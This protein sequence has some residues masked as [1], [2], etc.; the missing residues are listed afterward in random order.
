MHSLLPPEDFEVI[1]EQ[2]PGLCLIFD[3]SFRILAQN[4][5]HALATMTKRE[6]AIGRLLYEVF[7]DNPNDANAEGLAILRQS[8]VTV[9]KTCKPDIVPNLK[10]AIERQDG[11][12][13]LRYWRVLNTP[14][15]D[16]NGFVRLIIN[17]VDDLTSFLD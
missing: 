8:L 11:S 2:M 7:P 10:F 16:E 9:L 5:A 1:F 3:P 14:I 13:E 12:Y 15:L 6:E 4:N 17:R